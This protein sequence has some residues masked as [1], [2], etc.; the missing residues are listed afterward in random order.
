MVE[1]SK[2]KISELPEKVTPIDY[3]GFWCDISENE[4]IEYGVETI[5]FHFKE[6]FEELKRKKTN[7]IFYT[8]TPE[9]AIRIL[10][11][12]KKGGG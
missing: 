5:G 8:K 1:Y 4:F 3:C 12:E 11:T 6:M 7:F 10:F 9:Y 2:L